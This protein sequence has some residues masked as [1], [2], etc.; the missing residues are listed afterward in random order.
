MEELMIEV[1]NVGGDQCR[2]IDNYERMFFWY[3]QKALNRRIK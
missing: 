3:R 2:A 1:L